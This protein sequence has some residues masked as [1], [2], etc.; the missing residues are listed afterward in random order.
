MV[1]NDYPL[2]LLLRYM[3]CP[4]DYLGTETRRKLITKASWGKRSITCWNNM[5]ASQRA[6][7]RLKIFKKSLCQWTLDHVARDAGESV[8]S[9]NDDN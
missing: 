8:D 2:N 9:I 3:Y 7:Q 5:P 1:R 4:G 6:E